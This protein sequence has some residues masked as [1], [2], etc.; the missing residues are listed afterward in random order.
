MIDDFYANYESNF[1]FNANDGKYGKKG[2]LT[3]H[4]TIQEPLTDIVS[5][6]LD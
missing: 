1:T 5:M 2:G 6:W 3:I 4:A